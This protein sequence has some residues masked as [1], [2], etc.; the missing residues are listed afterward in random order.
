MLLGNSSPISIY[1]GLIKEHG[2][3]KV[4]KILESHFISHKAFNI[5]MKKSFTPADYE[6]FIAER[7]DTILKAIKKR[8]L[9]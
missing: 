3:D 9:D 5:L 2:K 7:E 8:V 6:N 4:L 1:Q